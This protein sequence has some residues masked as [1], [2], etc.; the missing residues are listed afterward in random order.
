MADFGSS[1]WAVQH[2]CFLCLGYGA[3]Y[4]N[5]FPGAVVDSCFVARF[6]AAARME[7]HFPAPWRTHVSWH[8]S[9]RRRTWQWSIVAARAVRR[10]A[11]S[12]LSRQG[13]N[14]INWSFCLR[15]RPQGRRIPAGMAW[16]RARHGAPLPT[17]RTFARMRA[18]ARAAWRLLP[19]STVV[20]GQAGRAPWRRHG[21]ARIPAAPD[22]ARSVPHRRSKNSWV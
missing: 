4:G 9:R 13:D 2:A 10:T 1:A 7:A 5:V 18:P 22:G 3:L 16:Q 17:T 12:A 21:P 6:Q 8:G 20:A 19:V 11:P 14:A 15:S